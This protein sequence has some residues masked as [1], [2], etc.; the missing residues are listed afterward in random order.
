MKNCL[1]ESGINR[2]I[3]CVCVLL[4]ACNGAQETRYV[5]ETLDGVES[6][7][8]S[9]PDSALAVLQAVDTSCLKTRALQARYSLLRVM[10]L[11]KNYKDIDQPGLLDPAIRYY[12]RHG[13]QRADR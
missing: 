4:C 13:F 7:L 11:D 2:V 9:R 10:A 1:I 6:Y 5:R 3:L 8:T 12:S